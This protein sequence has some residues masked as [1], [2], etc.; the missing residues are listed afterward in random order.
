MSVL[1]VSETLILSPS[2]VLKNFSRPEYNIEV[3]SSRQSGT[4]VTFKGSTVEPILSK[5]NVTGYDSESYAVKTKKDSSGNWTISLVENSYDFPSTWKTEISSTSYMTTIITPANITKIQFVATIPSGYTKIGT[6]S[7]GIPVYK[8]TTATDIAFVGKK[9]YAPVNSSKLFYQ[10]S[11]LTTLD[12]SIFDTSNVTNMNYMFSN[13][14]A[15][16]SLDVR[17]FNTSKVTDMSNMFYS[18]KSLT[19]LNISN[20][21]TSK[22]T[23]MFFMFFQ[24]SGLTN[25]DVSSFNT[26]NV[27]DMSGMFSSCKNC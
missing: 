17:G 25:L 5:I 8:G 19:S 10:L 26:T 15:L 7:T 11:N 20:F 18:C 4:I 6:L 12:M 21:N 1:K 2:F 23:N 16:T 3:S 24:C 9:I 14:S 27:T 22:V 13:C